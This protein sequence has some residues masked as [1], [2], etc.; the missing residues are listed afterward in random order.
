MLVRRQHIYEILQ[1]AWVWVFSQQ[2]AITMEC[3]Q[4]MFNWEKSYNCW[5]MTFMGQLVK[6]SLFASQ[7]LLMYVLT[8]Y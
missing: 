4:L 7:C 2:H 6:V 8:E 3:I 5:R 1:S